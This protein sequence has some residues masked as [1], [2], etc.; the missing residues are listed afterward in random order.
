[1]PV[2][3]PPYRGFWAPWSSV[4]SCTSNRGTVLPS[5]LFVCFAPIRTVIKS[6]LVTELDNMGIPSTGEDTSLGSPRP[7]SHQ[8]GCAYGGKVEG[9]TAPQMRERD[10]NGE[11]PN[12]LIVMGIRLLALI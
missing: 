11:E 5:P 4:H 3:D 12:A 6:F 9:V 2:T 7:W 1:M 10:R 8:L